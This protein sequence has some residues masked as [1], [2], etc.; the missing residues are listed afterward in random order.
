MSPTRNLAWILCFAVLVTEASADQPIEF[1]PVPGFVQLP[2][3][4][5]L[6]ACSAVAVNSTGEI[7]LFHRKKHPII[8]LNSEGKFLRSW[9]DQYI[10]TAHGLRIDRDDNLWVTD[11]ERH[12]AFKFN[13]QGKLL[14]A[15]GTGMPGS[16]TDQFNLP[17]DIAFGA[18]GNVYISDGYGN[19][20][21]MKFNCQGR[22]LTTWGTPGKGN[23]EFRL[24]HA[25]VVDAKGRVLVGDREN[26]R[27]QIF[28]G[29]GKL[30]DI[31]KGFAP[32]GLAFD[33][34]GRLFVADG[35]GGQVLQLNRQ[36][37][38]VHAWGGAGTDPGEFQMPH[39][40][41]FDA[42]GNLYVAEVDGQRVQK[43]RRR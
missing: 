30:L 18:Q 19:A 23:G 29:E 33:H 16:D 35:R 28:D 6:G 32:F 24:P 4:V 25:I 27:I 38:V 22:F 1:E 5:E 17:T 42:A 12:R 3:G 31:W 40:L 26:N 21:V 2:S 39:S 34:E 8:C 11:V 9:G 37:R 15:L 43:F 13:P 14:L 7:Y 10:R 41:A 36:G 20:R